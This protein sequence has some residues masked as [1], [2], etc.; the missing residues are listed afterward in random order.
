MGRSKYPSIELTPGRV[1]TGRDK[2][3]YAS[4][5]GDILKIY[6]K[7]RRTCGR[8][9]GTADS[10]GEYIY[11]SEL[12][13]IKLGD[14]STEEDKDEPLVF[15]FRAIGAD[16]ILLDSYRP[17]SLFH[18]LDGALTDILD[19]AYPKS[20]KIEG[21]VQEEG[22][23]PMRWPLFFQEYLMFDHRLPRVE[24]YRPSRPTPLM[25]VGVDEPLWLLIN[26]EH[27]QKD[28]GA[29]H[30]Y[31]H[32]NVIRRMERNHSLCNLANNIIV[33]LVENM[34]GVFQLKYRGEGNK[35]P[36]GRRLTR[37]FN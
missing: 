31:E 30:Y 28:F 15:H 8:A 6:R 20:K 36:T 18:G 11:Y 16:D 9:F 37:F 34:P 23:R 5:R 13:G 35:T 3:L 24:E 14:L 33:L 4:L 1:V 12:D 2:Q 25:Y 10:D 22:I 29:K 19:F 7:W 21:I 17:G 26:L 27:F 32:I